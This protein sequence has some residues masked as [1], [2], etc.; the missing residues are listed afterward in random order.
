MYD[1]LLLFILVAHYYK[2]VV[3]FDIVTNRGSN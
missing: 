2:I 3:I 1:L